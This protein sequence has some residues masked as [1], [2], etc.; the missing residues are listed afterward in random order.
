MFFKGKPVLPHCGQ[1]EPSLD[2]GSL[3]SQSSFRMQEGSW[4]FS[5]KHIS[6][7]PFD[8][9]SRKMSQNQMGHLPPQPP[10]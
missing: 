7:F 8:G 4:L 2:L 3:L 9:I 6:Q 1:D 10:S 5:S